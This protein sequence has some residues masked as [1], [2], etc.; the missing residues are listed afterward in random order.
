M[1][2]AP[3]V[4]AQPAG[5]GDGALAA[6]GRLTVA[7]SG[8]GFAAAVSSRVS[9]TEIGSGV[10]TSSGCH[11]IEPPAGNLPC[12]RANQINVPITKAARTVK[13]AGTRK[14]VQRGHVIGESISIFEIR[15]QL[16]HD[17][18]Q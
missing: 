14:S 17:P 18:R 4:R 6:R 9:P 8:K 2:V 5:N 7:S 13:T 1:E 10:A 3:R 12:Q 11:F 16:L 15:K